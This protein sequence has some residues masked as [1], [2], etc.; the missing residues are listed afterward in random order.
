M[1]TLLYVFPHPDDESFG[2]APALAHQR[3]QGHDVHVLT[4]TRGEA[5]QQRHRLGLSKEEMGAV[6]FG[7]MQHVAKALDLSSLDVL[8]LPDGELANLSPLTIEDAVTRQLVRLRP[9][10]VI[11]Y[12]VHGV[13]GHPDHLVTHAVVK[14]AVC[15]A[16]VHDDVPVRRLAF[17]T[18]QDNGTPRPD[19][20]KTSPDEA[21]DCVVPADEEAFAAA[22]AALEC[23][24]T[25]APVVE[26]H[27][28]LET[29]RNGV[30]F[31]CFRE[32]PTPRL[33]DLTAHLPAQVPLGSP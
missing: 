12:A 10:V 32:A 21:I 26:E 13:S 4:L 27:R 33:T 5:T 17:F 8:N 24:E 2:P 22:E 6:R 23:Y 7:E 29:V 19:H 30:C 18:L 14:R 25:Y 20:L 15:S 16:V 31:E 3:A 1:A 28:P 9:D 11:T